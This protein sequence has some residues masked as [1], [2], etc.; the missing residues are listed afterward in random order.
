MQNLLLFI[1]IWKGHFTT[2]FELIWCF[3]LLLA[4]IYSRSLGHFLPLINYHMTPYLSASRCQASS[5]SISAVCRRSR[6][7]VT[8]WTALTAISSAFQIIYA[9]RKIFLSSWHNKLCWVGILCSVPLG[10]IYH[11]HVMVKHLLLV[12]TT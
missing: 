5:S 10:I 9:K 7:P 11:S 6:Y 2:R 8:L 3:S 12:E 1:S 4:P